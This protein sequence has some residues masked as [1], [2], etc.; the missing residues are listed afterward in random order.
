MKPEIYADAET[1]NAELPIETPVLEEPV[2]EESDLEIISEDNID[3]EPLDEDALAIIERTTIPYGGNSFDNAK[4]LEFPEYYFV[5]REKRLNYY[6]KVN[7]GWYKISVLEAG[8]YYF[9]GKTVY[10]TNGYICFSLANKYQEYVASTDW[11]TS[12]MVKAE[13]EA[14]QTYY[15]EYDMKKYLNPNAEKADLAICTPTK[16][17]VPLSIGEQCP[18]CKRIE[19]GASPQ[20]PKPTAI[21]TPAPTA[22]FTPVPTAAPTVKPTATPTDRKSVV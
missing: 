11:D 8:T 13:L 1:A 9:Y 6:D 10:P 20:T 16:H 21:I 18:A 7:Y 3:I 15:L 19:T 22:T 14:N 2:L 17:A 4:N 5:E 12:F